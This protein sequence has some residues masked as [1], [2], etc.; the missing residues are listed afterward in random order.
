MKRRQLRVAHPNGLA[1]EAG[2]LAFQIGGWDLVRLVSHDPRP[3]L[4]R[5]Q[6]Q[7]RASSSIGR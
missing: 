6:L 4:G 1:R 5:C 2:Q 7:R 3:S